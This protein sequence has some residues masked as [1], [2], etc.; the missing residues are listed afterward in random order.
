MPPYI[1]P[2]GTF[3]TYKRGNLTRGILA[4]KSFYSHLKSI[5]CTVWKF[6]DFCI[7]Q[8]LRE[9]NFEDSWS[10]KLAIFT[11][12]EAAKFDFY[13]FLHFLKFE[14]YQIK[15]IPLPQNGKNGSVGTSKF[16]KIDFM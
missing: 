9:I 4:T 3:S 12:L 5:L 16:F 7:I 11:H 1:F 8:I 10:P 13:E 15:T 6:Q 2:Q 14:I